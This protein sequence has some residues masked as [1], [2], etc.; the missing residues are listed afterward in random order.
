[1]NENDL[2]EVNPIASFEG[3]EFL[4]E[5]K[6]FSLG[7]KYYIKDV[8]GNNIAFCE[9]KSFSLK[10]DLKLFSEESKTDELFRIKQRNILDLTGTFEVIETETDD[11]LGFLKRNWAKSV[12]LGEWKI[13][14]KNKEVIAEAI[15]DSLVKEVLRYKGLKKL[16]YRYKLYRD[17]KKIGFCKQRLSLVKNVY[18]IQFDDGTRDMLDRRLFISLALLLDTVEKKWKIGK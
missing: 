12:L 8:E 11:T 10:S 14:D 1:M 18:K 15:E 6:L 5:K 2:K 3:D 16:P 9:A 7:N 4:I 17:G 13:F